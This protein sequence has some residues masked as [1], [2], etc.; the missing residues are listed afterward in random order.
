MASVIVQWC[1]QW[2]CSAIYICDISD[3]EHWTWFSYLQLLNYVK[4][5]TFQASIMLSNVIT[6][7]PLLVAVKGLGWLPLEMKSL[8]LLYDSLTGWAFR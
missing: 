6:N 7:I 2:P 5:M 3:K 1:A 4:A 8:Y